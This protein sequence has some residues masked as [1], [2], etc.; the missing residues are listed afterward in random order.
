MRAERFSDNTS[1]V[2]SENN[3]EKVSEEDLNRIRAVAVEAVY[4][5]IELLQPLI[6]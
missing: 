5:L 1:Y 2:S 4:T 6:L 3:L